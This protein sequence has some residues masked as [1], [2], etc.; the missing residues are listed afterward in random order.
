MPP[1]PLLGWLR[2]RVSRKLG[3]AVDPDLAWCGAELE[4]MRVPENYISVNAFCEH[5]DAVKKA[6]CAGW[7][8]GMDVRVKST[9]GRKELTR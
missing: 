3:D 6:C 4:R 1:A 2:E 8:A 7:G 5:A 9:G